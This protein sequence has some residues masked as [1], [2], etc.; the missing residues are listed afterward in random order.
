VTL[1]NGTKEEA[2]AMKQELATFLRTELKLTLS[3]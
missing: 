1:C 3:V 2:E